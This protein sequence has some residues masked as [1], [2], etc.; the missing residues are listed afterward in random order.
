MIKINIQ[1]S[2]T[3]EIERVTYTANRI[4]TF[5]ERRYKFEKLLSPK[6]IPYQDIKLMTETEIKN[7]VTEDY[8]TEDYDKN[9][10]YIQDRWLQIEPKFK[11]EV[12]KMKIKIIPE[13]DIIFTKY[14]ITGSYKSPNI[15]FVNIKNNVVRD[16]FL[17][18]LHQSHL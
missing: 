15:I 10:K 12:E 13:F 2:I 14:G 6:N 18:R 4:N 1:Y 7:L 16:L 17:Q 3:K 8:I 11:L 9:I 5:S